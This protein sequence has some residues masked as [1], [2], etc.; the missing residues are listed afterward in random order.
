MKRHILTLVRLA[1]FLVF[2]VSFCIA[3]T[4]SYAADDSKLKELPLDKAVRVGMG[5]NTIIEF[6]DPDCPYCRKLDSYLK[7]RKDVTRY[8]FLFPLTQLH[9]KSEEKSKLVLC[10]K[11]PAGTLEEVMSGQYDKEMPKPCNDE[12]NVSLLKEF[13]EIGLKLGITATPSL[14]VNGNF[15]SGANIQAIEQIIGPIK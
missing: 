5:K 13:R 14:Y 1:V 12:K 11:N 6:T 15:I 2:A 10:S 3:S 8:I 9:P 7:Q 4:R